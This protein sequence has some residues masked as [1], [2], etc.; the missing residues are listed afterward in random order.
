MEMHEVYEIKEEV[1]L[2]SANVAIQYE[3]W[4]LLGFVRG[5]LN[6]PVVYVLGKKKPTA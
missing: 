2:E 3:G 5:T 6:G 1:H 4:T